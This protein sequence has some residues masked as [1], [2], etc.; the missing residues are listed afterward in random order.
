MKKLIIA[1]AVA[2]TTTTALAANYIRVPAPKIIGQVSSHPAV[3]GGG[4][5]PVVPPTPEPELGQGLLTGIAFGD[6]SAGARVVRHAT[7]S[8]TGKR[9]LK[10]NSL[11]VQGAGFSLD[12]S[13]CSDALAA[14][15]S[16]VLNVALVG[17]GVAAHA[18]A[19]QVV[20]DQGTLSSTLTAQ[21]RQA[22]LAVTPLTAQVFG[23]VQTGA[24]SSSPTLVK[25]ENTGN[26]RTSGFKVEPPANYT[27]VDST[28]A[29]EL[30]AGA[31]CSF[32]VQF[33]PT[34]AIAYAGDV[35]VQAAG[36]DSS[37]FSVSGQGA[38][39]AG[40]LTPTLSFGSMSTGETVD[41]DAILRN[42]GVGPLKLDGAPGASSLTGS[43]AYSFL[44]SNCPTTLSMSAT[45]SIKLRFTAP[46]PAVDIAGALTL[47][48]AAGRLVTTL[49]GTSAAS[50]LSYSLGAPGTG[51]YN[52]ANGV[53]GG[54]TQFTYRGITVTAGG[55]AGGW[56]N[57]NLV[58]AGGVGSG[59]TGQVAGGS[60]PGAYGDVGGSG[61]G[62]IGGVASSTP[63]IGG[64]SGAIALDVSGLKAALAAANV[65]FSGPGAMGGPVKCSNCAHGGSASGFGAGGG[66]AGYSSGNGGNGK[67]GGGG[68]GA[69]GQVSYQNGGNGGQGVLVIQFT[70]STAVMLTSG[71]SYAPTKV[72]KQ[73]WA[74][75]AGGGGA[76]ATLVANT[77]GGGGAAGAVAY[78][79]Y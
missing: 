5:G 78:Q 9:A 6:V 57:S 15:A 41:L 13:T 59:G 56:Y 23:T 26:L 50:T 20:T 48:T 67:Y 44:S 76:G 68:G 58:A 11:T 2:A 22:G 36:L 66:G 4:P 47:E 45:C 28:C 38:A 24:A 61:G 16:C 71:S 14:D 65:V 39:P 19:V 49:K 52:K 34:Q 54:V 69:A 32:K 55:G 62:G 63:D 12:S 31:D 35:K 21:S 37:Q 8:N 72:I 51:G 75:G 1:L 33:A 79:T 53:A 30:A 64:S 46:A 7:L 43:A 27:L 25:V 10:V 40:T 77:A 17:S 73:I 70:D 74:V 29:G 3:Q 60:S 18:G 42:T